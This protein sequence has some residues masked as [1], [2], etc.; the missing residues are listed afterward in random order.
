MDGESIVEGIVLYYMYIH[1]QGGIDT[2]SEVMHRCK[3]L[4]REI[5]RGLKEVVYII[6]I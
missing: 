5:E 3:H 2:L 1:M 4:T 6:H